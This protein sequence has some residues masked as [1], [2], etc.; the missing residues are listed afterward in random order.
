MQV[1]TTRSCA[2][3]GDPLTLLESRLRHIEEHGPLSGAKG[4]RPAALPQIK[5]SGALGSAVEFTPS[6]STKLDEIS[7]IVHDVGAHYR[8]SCAACSRV[9]D[10]G[11][12][13]LLTT[14]PQ[15]VNK[16]TTAESQLFKLILE[17]LMPTVICDTTQVEYLKTDPLVKQ[18]IR[19]YAEAPLVGGNDEYLGCLA[20]FGAE[21][22]NLS[23]SECT[24]LRASAAS[25]SD[26]IASAHEEL[27]EAPRSYST[28]STAPTDAED[29]E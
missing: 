15:Q 29:A 5:E 22:R 8:L 24:A 23:L 6:I 18:G 3:A 19:F 25:I 27:R 16:E 21:P 28:V 11:H 26:M 4:I 10:S 14:A 2:K 7:A 9:E 1:V 20:I 12:Q 13:V 17:R